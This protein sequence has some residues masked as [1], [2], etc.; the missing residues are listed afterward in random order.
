MARDAELDSLVAW[1]L[2][3]ARVGREKMQQ[4]NDEDGRGQRTVATSLAETP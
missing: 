1:K 4:T 2:R 3:R